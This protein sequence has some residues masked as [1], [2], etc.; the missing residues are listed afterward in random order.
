VVA[1]V[2]GP[3]GDIQPLS[4]TVIRNHAIIERNEDELTLIAGS[5]RL[6]ALG[7]LGTLVDTGHFHWPWD[8]QNEDSLYASCGPRLIS[9]CKVLVHSCPGAG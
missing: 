9:P 1:Q 4:L 2:F 8:S 5:G 7:T 6:I 3:K